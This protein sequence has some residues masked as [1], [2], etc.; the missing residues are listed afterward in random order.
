MT[1][2]TRTYLCWKSKNL[3]SFGKGANKRNKNLHTMKITHYTVCSSKKF[4]CCIDVRVTY[5]NSL[6]IPRNNILRIIYRHPGLNIYSILN[7][8]TMII[9]SRTETKMACVYLILT[10][11]IVKQISIHSHKAI[12]GFKLLI[13]YT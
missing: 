11:H 2:C 7:S 6:H 12:S 5:L 8:N 3:F 4:E 10:S 13:T 1:D 9:S